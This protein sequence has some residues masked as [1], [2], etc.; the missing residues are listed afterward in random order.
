[1]CR[2]LFCLT[3][4]VLVLWLVMGPSPA[5]GQ[6]GLI[7]YWKFDE[8]SGTTAEDSAGG[9][10][11]GTLS[12]NVEWQP[13][14]GMSGGAILLDG[15]STAHVEIPS[16]GIL[17]SSGTV[18]VWGYLSAPQ[19]GQTRYFFGHTT[20][21]PY[22]NRIQLYMDGGNTELDLGLGDSH[23]R[24]TNIMILELETWYH[25]ALTWDK[26]D[27]VV[28][29]DGEEVASGTY[30]GLAGIHEF[31]WIGNDGNPETEGVEAF[32]GLLDEVRIYNRA[33]NPAE[34]LAAM[35]GEPFTKAS[36][37]T[38]KDGALHTDTWVNLA[39]R[40]GDFAVSH[41]IYLG[42]SFDDVNE[43][44]GD[45]FRGNQ[46][47]V[48]YV[49]GFPGVAF[50]EGLVPGTTKPSRIVPG[51][52]MYGASRFHQRPP[53]VPSRLMATSSYL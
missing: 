33:L 35:K 28:Y 44:A 16:T 50:P 51:K 22:N 18:A 45:T 1:M 17:A 53:T 30:T 26:S 49:A 3:L 27:Y 36:G 25:V 20:Q 31:A 42:D 4:F 21:P 7:G 11:N 29:V 34:I 23:T 40:A 12:D 32:G 37:P 5:Y 24:Q 38:P 46:T 10:N 39:W 19:P 13:G 8:T 14:G 15:T 43:G 48:F 52:V 6:E 9:D 41:D 2:K 47:D